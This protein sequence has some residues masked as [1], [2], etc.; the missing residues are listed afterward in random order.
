MK[1]H[2][3]PGDMIPVGM[4]VMFFIAG[5]IA[6]TTIFGETRF[7]LRLGCLQAVYVVALL[8]ALNHVCQNTFIHWSAEHLQLGVF[9]LFFVRSLLIAILCTCFAK[10]RKDPIVLIPDSWSLR[11]KLLARGTLGNLVILCL[12]SAL[13]HIPAPF[14]ALVYITKSIWASIMCWIVLRERLSLKDVL[15][16]ILG[17]VAVVLLVYTTLDRTTLQYGSS[18][19][20]MGFGFALAAAVLGGINSVQIRAMGMKVHYATNVF[21][22][23][24]TG[25][26]FCIFLALGAPSQFAPLLHP[27]MVDLAI[28][29]IV[30]ICSFMMQV[31]LNKAFALAK[32]GPLVLFTEASTLAIQFLVDSGLGYRYSVFAWISAAL[33]GLYMV[34]HFGLSRSIATKQEDKNCVLLA[35]TEGPV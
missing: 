19:S 29:G 3:M 32:A 27:S 7:G 31:T 8:S 1:A 14:V 26:V 5:A 10:A 22:L 28:F 2:V 33:I 34:L 21:A 11:R 12:F 23:A 16:M 25:L 13:A 35:H 20:I 24:M 18:K 6:A 17:L 4:K 15:S 30:G 9:L